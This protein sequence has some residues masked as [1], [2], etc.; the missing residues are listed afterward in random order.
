MS[1][2]NP[3][4]TYGFVPTP[5]Q[6][7]T[8]WSLKCDYSQVSFLLTQ[9]SQYFVLATPASGTGVPVFRQLTYSDI[10]ATGSVPASVVI[11]SLLAVAPTLPTSPSQLVYGTPAIW[12]NG[13][14]LAYYPG[15]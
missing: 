11:A 9:Q 15:T 10:A 2:S 4:W 14:Q 12:L 6:W 5:N 13:G 1:G 8:E 3:G 7:N